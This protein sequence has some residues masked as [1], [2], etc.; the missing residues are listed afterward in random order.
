MAKNRDG[1]ETV[2]GKSKVAE[3]LWVAG[4]KNSWEDKISSCFGFFACEQAA[5]DYQARNR[6]NCCNAVESRK[7]S[8]YEVAKGWGLA[9]IR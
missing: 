8:P 4:N 7:L 5:R 3:T 2:A 6:F 9:I 1:V